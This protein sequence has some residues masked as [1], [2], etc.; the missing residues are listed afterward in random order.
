MR[1]N[2]RSS[3]GSVVVGDLVVDCFVTFFSSFSKYRLSF[4]EGHHEEPFAHS[5]PHGAKKINAVGRCARQQTA[6]NEHC[7]KHVTA[8]QCTTTSV[9]S[10]TIGRSAVLLVA[11][12]SLH[13]VIEAATRHHQVLYDSG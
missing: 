6:A 9:T 7:S 5:R 13:V 3:V 4:A 12:L 10:A 11:R 2:G 1:S 8:Q